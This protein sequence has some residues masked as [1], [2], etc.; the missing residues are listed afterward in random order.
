MFSKAF[1][2]TLSLN[3][4]LAGKIKI[5]DVVLTNSKSRLVPHVKKKAEDWVL[6]SKVT[7]KEHKIPILADR[8]KISAHQLKAHMERVE[9][10]ACHARWAANE[11]GTH[12]IYNEET[13]LNRWRDWN[14]PAF[15]LP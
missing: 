7:G 2:K 11:W 10:S 9:C 4:N 14:F 8:P 5:G 6:I 12:V 3:P 15:A 1:L 13:N